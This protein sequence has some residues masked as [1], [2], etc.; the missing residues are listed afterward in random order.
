[1]ACENLN[2]PC[3]PCASGLPCGGGFQ[4]PSRR[5]TVP[6]PGG[7]PAL[8]AARGRNDR[9]TFNG[10]PP[11]PGGFINVVAEGFDTV[12]NVL[13]GGRDVVDDVSEAICDGPL[14]Q[15]VD[16]IRKPFSDFWE[17]QQA[18]IQ[19]VATIASLPPFI[20]FGSLLEPFVFMGD[21]IGTCKP[22]EATGR[23]A[24]RMTAKVTFMGPFLQSQAVHEAVQNTAGGAVASV[25]KAV[26]EA[27]KIAE[28]V[29]KPFCNGD[30][31]SG[32][33]VTELAFRLVALAD[34]IRQ[35]GGP[36]ALE[37]AAPIL[38]PLL[39]EGI[40]CIEAGG[41]PSECTEQALSGLSGARIGP[42]VGVIGIDLDRNGNPINTGST[43][44]TGSTDNT[45]TPPA[46]AGAA[47]PVI[48]IGLL[49]ALL[50]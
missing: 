1:M 40:A 39:G 29:A 31:P 3:S 37:L 20:A 33:D 43:G 11:A 10:R 48:G 49:Y 46:A 18:A 23:A 45:N 26:G 14:G 47:A 35:A 34:L 38:G 41:D 2:A 7:S 22:S 17:G 15:A 9:R 6:A 28:L 27:M 19:T 13:R 4:S 36:N 30:V 8:T 44:S 32:R 5:V 50:R 16:G 42:L 21:L 12:G 25:I 24:C